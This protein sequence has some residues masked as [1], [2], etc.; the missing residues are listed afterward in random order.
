MSA[1]DSAVQFLLSKLLP[2]VHHLQHALSHGY[3]Q[4]PEVGGLTTKDV[5]HSQDEEPKV[6]QSDLEQSIL[7]SPSH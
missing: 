3:S 7:P 2:A 5:F 6:F 4:L 1:T